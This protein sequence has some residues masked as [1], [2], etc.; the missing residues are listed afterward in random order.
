LRDVIGYQEI[1]L[2]NAVVLS[3]CVIYSGKNVPGQEGGLQAEIGDDRLP[4]SMNRYEV[5]ISNGS[6]HHYA[7]IVKIEGDSVYYVFGC[8]VNLNQLFP[9]A[10]EKRISICRKIHFTQNI[11]VFRILLK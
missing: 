7:S 3:G 4:S 9:L 6:K 2:K 11:L 5:E 1:E 8:Q 10:G